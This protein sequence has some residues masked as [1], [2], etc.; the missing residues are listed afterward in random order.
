LQPSRQAPRKSESILSTEINITTSSNEGED[1]LFTSYKPLNSIKNKLAKHLTQ[2]PT[3][4]LVV[5]LILNH[6]EH[7]L[8]ALADTGARSSIIL[9]SYTSALFIKNDYN[10]TTTLNS[11]DCKFTTNKTG[12]CL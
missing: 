6:E 12:I 7:L 5:S 9:E 3:T 8:R 11:M 10:N 2:P 4:E 1:Y